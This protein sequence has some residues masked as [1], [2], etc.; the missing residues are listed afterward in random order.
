LIL[1]LTVQN[2]NQL[3]IYYKKY[4]RLIIKKTM[5]IL[6]KKGVVHIESNSS[7]DCIQDLIFASDFTSHKQYRSIFT[8]KATLERILG[9]R[10]KVALALLDDKTIVGFAA[11]D[12]PDTK[13]RW[14]R[15]GEK[16]MMEVKAVEVSRQ[17][18]NHGIARHLLS[19][20]LLD[21]ELEQKILYLSG[22]SW[23]WDLDYSGLTAPAYGKMLV[24]L[25]TDFGFFEYPTNE[26]NICLKPENI[27][28]ARVGKNILPKAL[29]NFK[30]LRFNLVF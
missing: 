24:Q 18:R 11:L 21:P 23:T 1:M 30:W 22:Y 13:D 15:L 2:S 7:Q 25:Y 16:I 10:G 17:I 5:R 9:R 20:L 8:K 6:T 14:S 29:E 28:M 27:F 4:G 19:A 26:P 3:K 12:Y